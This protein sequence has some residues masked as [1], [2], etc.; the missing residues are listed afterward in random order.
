MGLI[1]IPLEA[2]K[3]K[4]KSSKPKLVKVIRQKISNKELGREKKL[5]QKTALSLVRFINGENKL[6]SN[7]IDE[8]IKNLQKS[9]I[10]IQKHKKRRILK[11]NKKLSSKK[12]S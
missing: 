9:Q 1:P 6:S 8:L 11:K 3:K 10:Y 5:I 12:K 7:Q 2:G 4:R